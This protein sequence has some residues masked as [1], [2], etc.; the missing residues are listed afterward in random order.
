VNG[1]AA[2]RI[3]IKPDP[4]EPYR[5]AA[6]Y[7]V[8][9][10]IFLSGQAAINEAGEVV[11]VGDF[12]AQADQVF[13]NIAR[14]LEAAGSSLERV[15]KVM[16][17]LTDMSNFPKIVA[18]RERWGEPYPAD[19]IVEVTSLALPGLELE[20]DVTAVAGDGEIVG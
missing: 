3:A 12:D 4:L 1:P 6:G 5:I 13:R 2:Q 14:V 18:L 10:L 11:G 20:I 8:G 16:I 17:F 15:I 7:R 19:T 9:D